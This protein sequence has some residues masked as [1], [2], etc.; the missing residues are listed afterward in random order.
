MWTWN[1]AD[2][3][4]VIS[5]SLLSQ[6]L[7]P[8]SQGNEPIPDAYVVNNMFI[9][10]NFTVFANRT[11]GVIRLRLLNSAIY[12]M[13]NIS[14][15]GLPLTVIEIEGTAMKPLDVGYIVLNVGQRVSVLLNFSRLDPL[16]NATD[17][18]WIRFTGLPDMYPTY[19]PSL[20]DEGIAGATSKKKLNLNWVGRIIFNGDKTTIPKYNTT[21]IPFLNYTPITT[22]IVSARPLVPRP[23]ITASHYIHMQVVFQ[24]DS[25][26]VNR[27]Y[28]NGDYY[29]GNFTN[30]T[31]TTN[32]VMKTMYDDS[33]RSFLA[34]IAN[35]Q[36]YHI[37]GSS[38]HP[39]IVPFNKTIEIFINNTDTGEH[40]FHFHGHNFEIIATSADP[41]AE[42]LY[43]GNY[44]VRDV[45]SVPALGWA[46]IRYRSDNPGAWVMHW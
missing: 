35:S 14:I 1:F 9:E 3:Y 17:A 22:N 4:N 21:H 28:I 39:F 10:D 27:A 45:V 26:G 8:A 41:Q 15:D 5:R 19:D 25:Y 40:P 44:V 2:W 34:N 24:N 33:Y 37:N 12:S 23:D 31:S 32:Y 16:L 13:C 46:K 30:I 18:L 36:P 29:T 43:K 6:Y 7:I 11:E 42:N 38:M 20:A